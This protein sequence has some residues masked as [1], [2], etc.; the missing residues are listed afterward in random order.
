MVFD[1][2][3]GFEGPGTGGADISDSQR[4]FYQIQVTFAVYR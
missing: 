3:L 4:T 2:M 1:P